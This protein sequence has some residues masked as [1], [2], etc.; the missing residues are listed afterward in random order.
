LSAS[1][2]SPHCLRPAGPEDFD[3]LRFLEHVCFVPS[4]RESDR[5][6]RH[7][8]RSPFQEVWLLRTGGVPA[9]ALMLRLHPRTLRIFSIAVHPDFRGQG[10][11]DRLLA[12]AVKR[13]RERKASRMVLEV[14]A[15]NSS[16]VDW[17]ARHGFTP[18]RKLPGYYGS[19]SPGLRMECDLEGG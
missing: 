18:V 16:L 6:L 12:R 17:Y 14:D 8:L 3:H 1:A 10:L 2:R 13:A 9:G 11:G 4:R 7:A 5:A 19:R 15:K